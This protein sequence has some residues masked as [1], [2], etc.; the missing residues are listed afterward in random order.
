MSALAIPP[1]A[2]QTTKAAMATGLELW[3]LILGVILSPLRPAGWPV[4]QLLEQ[5]VDGESGGAGA[6]DSIGHDLAKLPLAFGICLWNLLSADK[7]AR[8][9]M[10]LEEPA[11][12]QLP[13]CADDGVGIDRRD[14]RR[15]GAR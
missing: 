13:V 2:M 1:A 3:M 14:R 5:I 8:A 12:L 15:A 9:L 4:P 11:E 7:R 6:R 10:G